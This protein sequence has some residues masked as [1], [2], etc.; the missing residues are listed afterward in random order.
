MKLSA[1]DFYLL[2]ENHK[3]R[4]ATEI[5]HDGLS[6]MFFVLKVLSDANADLSAGDVADIL[7][8]T[9]ARTAVVLSTLEKKGYITKSKS[10][11]DGRKTIV[12]L[13]DEGAMA[14]EERRAQLFGMVDQLLGK[15]S[16]IEVEQL[17]NILKK[18]LSY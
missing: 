15:L 13:N 6:G 9:T 11:I 7:G 5:M 10:S 8:V 14:L 16:K 17:H 18:L 4:A 12:R 2:F 3:F 1:K